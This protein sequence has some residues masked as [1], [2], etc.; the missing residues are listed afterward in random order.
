LPRPRGEVIDQLYGYHCDHTRQ[1]TPGHSYDTREN[2]P[3][4]FLADVSSPEIA[5]QADT[6]GLAGEKVEE[7]TVDT[8]SNLFLTSLRSTIAQPLVE[9]TFFEYY[10]EVDERPDYTA[11]HVLPFLA[12]TFS[13]YSRDF[14]IGWFG[15]KRALLKQFAA[16]WNVMGFTKNIMV[17][18]EAR[19]LGPDLPPNCTWASLEEL[20]EHS[21]ALVF[22]FGIAEPQ[23]RGVLQSDDIIDAIAVGFQRIIGRERLRV[24]RDKRAPRPIVGVNTS[25]THRVRTMFAEDVAAAKAPPSTRVRVGWVTRAR[26]CMPGLVVGEAGIRAPVSAHVRTPAIHAKAGVAGTLSYGPYYALVPGGY[27]VT[28]EF[29]IERAT[30]S[31]SFRI[32]VATLRGRR[33]LAQQHIKP[34]AHMRNNQNGDATKNAPLTCVLP[35][36]M[37]TDAAKGDEESVEFR[38][39]SPG[40]IGFSLVALSLRE[41]N[42]L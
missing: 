28:Y 26:D 29:Q 9:P 34:Y 3:Q 4:T 35:F 24:V 22:D 37:T 6:W 21:Q 12:G 15:A 13:S 16:S 25:I 19:W 5:E 31:S 33:I 23:G 20:N 18:E 11:E 38:V 7:L 40:T 1:L 36:D 2:D 8:T 27:E 30:R 39:W 14:T 32:D 17:F 41:S 42:P 10:G